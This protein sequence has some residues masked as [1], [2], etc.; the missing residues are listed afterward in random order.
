ME[1]FFITD[2]TLIRD[3][4]VSLFDKDWNGITITPE[5]IHPNLLVCPIDCRAKIMDMIAQAQDSI[6]VYHQYLTDPALTQ[7]IHQKIAA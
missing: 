1:H 2:N 6:Y 4:L 3:N 7:L 5:D